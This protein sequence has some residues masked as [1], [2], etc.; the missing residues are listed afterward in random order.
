MTAR[1][2]LYTALIAAAF[3]FWAPTG[4]AGMME[5]PMA[6]AMSGLLKGAGDHRAT[7]TV[8]IAKDASG[9]PILFLTDITV[10]KVP[11]G[12]VYLAKNGDYTKGVELG[13]LTKFS[14]TVQ[15]A[16]PASV[17]MADYDSV[18]I[19]CRKFSVEIGHAMFDMG[20]MKNDGTMMDK[21]KGMMK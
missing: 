11:D 14:G 12:R 9:N 6:G 16:I 4:Y 7:G 10:D 21:E 8:S 15:Y 17:N 5:D 19:W 20:M 13:K 18:V 3:G 1:H 2:L